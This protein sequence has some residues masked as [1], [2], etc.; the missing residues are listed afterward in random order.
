ML[1]KFE[2]RILALFEYRPV[3]SLARLVGA[4]PDAGCTSAYRLALTYLQDFPG[5]ENE[6]I[7]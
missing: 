1:A 7:A 6:R 4:H 2:S 3:A 5:A